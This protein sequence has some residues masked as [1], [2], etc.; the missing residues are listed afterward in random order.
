MRCMQMHDMTWYH[1]AKDRSDQTWYTLHIRW[2]MQ[3][4]LLQDE[5]VM[6]P[7]ILSDR[8][9]TSHLVDAIDFEQALLPITGGDHR[10]VAHKMV[11]LRIMDIADCYTM[12]RDEKRAINGLVWFRET[13]TGF[14][15]EMIHTVDDFSDCLASIREGLAWTIHLHLP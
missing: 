11:E 4:F 13:D 15:P 3:Y 12:K 8:S 7:F 1:F 10:P 9:H 2:G 14:Q 5:K 6:G